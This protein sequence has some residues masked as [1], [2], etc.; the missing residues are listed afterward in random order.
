[1]SFHPD[2]ILAQTALAAVL[3]LFVVSCGSSKKES[4]PDA[5][6]DTA[7]EPA[8]TDAGTAE[9]PAITGGLG[10]LT[11]VVRDQAG[12][13]VVGAK[14]AVG[15]V[16]MFTDATGK[17]TLTKLP[18]GDAMVSVSQSWFQPLQQPAVVAADTTTPLDL[19]LT[20]MPLKID[21]ADR[22]LVQT[23]N[24]SYD[25]SKQTISMAIAETPTRRNFD[26]AIFLRNPAL[27]RNTSTVAA[28]TPAIAPQIVGGVASGF[29]FP[30]LSGVN[31]GQQALEPAT[32]VD[33]IKDTPFGAVEP[34]DFMMW[35]AMVNWLIEW[36]ASKSTIVKLAGLAV[37]NQG[38]GANAIRPQDIE[39][40]FLDPAT[41]KLWVKIV[42]ENF[43]QLGPGVTDDDGDGR[44][45]IYAALAPVHTSAEI[46]TALTTD[47][48]AKVFTTHSLSKEVSKSLNELYS[49]TGA[50]VERTIGQP[51]E[52]AGV[53]TIAYPFMVLRH[54]GGQKN[55]ILVGPG[56]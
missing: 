20:E 54:S 49:T 8:V 3:S 30:V 45:E 38:W 11:G 39:K 17:Y 43:V 48:M 33:N 32:I 2:R 22:A 47:Y 40:V 7:V 18:A 44:K 34:A 4:S 37:R 36:N 25:W 50:Q 52:V 13:P 15:T 21:P 23:Y 12:V 56:I 24:Q 16:S 35:T 29:D 53:G 9:T 6:V 19:A 42:F 10:A 31:Q 5:A 1:V 41:G 26:N 55:V 46:L 14:V 51:F 28:V 27:Y